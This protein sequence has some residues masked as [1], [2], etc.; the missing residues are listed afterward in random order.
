[1]SI[2][3]PNSSSM[4]LG[5]YFDGT[6]ESGS[7]VAKAEATGDT[8]FSLG[9]KWN[10]IKAAYKLTDDDMFNLFNKRALDDAVS[11]GKTIRFS[12]NPYEWKET[13]LA[14]EWDYLQKKHKY[15]S[16]IKKGE[17]WYATK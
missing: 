15:K 13:T 14:R 9:E 10:E 11:Q 7:Y 2:H 4:T 1:M 16:L 3:N 6:I 12:Q 8:Y 5:K 17:Y